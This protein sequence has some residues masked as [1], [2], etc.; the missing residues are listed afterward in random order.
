MGLPHYV[1]HGR[2]LENECELKLAACGK[3]EVV[4]RTELV[5]RKAGRMT[6]ELRENLSH[7]TYLA[8]RLV[9]LRLETNRVVLKDS[10]VA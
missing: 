5:L 2:K 3:S 1:V 9:Q 4:P 10:Y 6:S 8:R 7:T